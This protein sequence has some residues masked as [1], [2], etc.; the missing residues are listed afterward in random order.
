M[1]DGKI[2]EQGTHPELLAL[3]GQY[4]NLASKSNAPTASIFSVICALFVIAYKSF[5]GTENLVHCGNNNHSSVVLTQKEA[6][7]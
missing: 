7:F 4:Y 3:K 1:N 6:S 2:V 5:L